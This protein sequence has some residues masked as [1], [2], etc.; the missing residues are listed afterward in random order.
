EEPG[1][2]EAHPPPMFQV[3]QSQN[4]IPNPVPAY[5]KSYNRLATK[6][7]NCY[8][9]GGAGHTA[10]VYLSKSAEAGD[11][12]QSREVVEKIHKPAA[13]CIEPRRKRGSKTLQTNGRTKGV[14]GEGVKSVRKAG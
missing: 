1:E 14:V 10:A 9:C 11:T 7:F 3:Y 5:Q 12:D 6:Q 2:V 13:E 4:V 8:F